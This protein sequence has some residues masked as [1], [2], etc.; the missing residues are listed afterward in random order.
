MKKIMLMAATVMMSLAAN[1][2]NPDGLKKVMSASN[3]SEA[4]GLLKTVAATMTN[5]EKAKAYNK[6]VDLAI[7]ESTK[8]E[9]GAVKAQLAQNTDEMNKLN[10]PLS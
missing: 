10:I 6:L 1:A 2:Q 3:Y 9:E 4:N 8:A 7:T 5:V